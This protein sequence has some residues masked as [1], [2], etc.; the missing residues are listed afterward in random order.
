MMTSKVPC[1]IGNCDSFGGGTGM[2][3][4]VYFILSVMY[5]I[6]VWVA[7]LL[8]VGK[9]LAI[10]D[11]D[12]VEL[13]RKCKRL[14]ND[15]KHHICKIPV[16]DVPQAVSQTDGYNCGI[17]GILTSETTFTR[18]T[19]LSAPRQ[20]SHFASPPEVASYLQIFQTPPP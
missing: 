1:F 15:R 7:K 10:P 16:Q 12:L 19:I 14:A 5:K 20:A 13:G 3:S 11:L 9:N 8:N 18:I 4:M 17:F 6:K 2:N